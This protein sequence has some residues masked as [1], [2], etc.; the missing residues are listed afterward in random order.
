LYNENVPLTSGYRIE[1]ENGSQVFQYDEYGVA[2]NNKKFAS[3]Q[4]I[5]PL[6]CRM[7][8]PNGELIPETSYE[9]I[10]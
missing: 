5:L 8:D 4:E 10:T 6:I 1:I 7:Y 9:K 2:P 3:P